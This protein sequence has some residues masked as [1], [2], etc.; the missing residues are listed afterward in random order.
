MEIISYTEARNNL[1]HFMDKVCEDRDVLT[2]M[3]QNHAPVVMMSLDE[4]NGINETLHL[5]SSRNNADRIRQGLESYGAGK[6]ESHGLI[7]E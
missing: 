2:I 3:R 5:L 7:E 4:F 1:A 6:T